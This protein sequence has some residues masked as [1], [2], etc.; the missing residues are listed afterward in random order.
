MATF[1]FGATAQCALPLDDFSLL[2]AE[3]DAHPTLGDP[4]AA[5]EAALAAPIGFPPL[6]AATAPGDVVAIAVAD[7][8]PQTN[9]IVTGAVKALLEAGVSPAMITIV[10]S[11]KF[12]NRAEL[13]QS[14]AKL[15]AEE[16]K[17]ELHD[18]DDE[19]TIAMVGVNSAKEPLRLNRTL[20]EADLVLP[21]TVQRLPEGA[22]PDESKFAG[23]FPQ[24]SSRET[25]ARVRLESGN[26]SPKV[27]KRLRA[28][29]DE[30]GW[31]LG[32]QMI[33]TVAP[34][35]NGGVAGVL[36]GDPDAVA[37]A[38]AA[39]TRE[40]WEQSVATPGDLVIAG[41]SGSEREQTWENVARAVAAASLVVTPGGAI[42]VCSELET[43]P[44]GPLLRL[45]EAVDFNEVQ[46]ELTRDEANDAHPAVVLA[47]AL[48]EGPVYLRSR[49]PSDVVESLGMTPIESDAELARLA[50]GR[51]HTIII[52]EAQRL[53]PRPIIRDEW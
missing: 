29:A 15:N 16:M 37:K 34:G 41:V 53:T 1:R 13:E 51:E 48:E 7:G 24:F 27:Q 5:V 47:K 6:V 49:L 17:F 20:A 36:A 26:E 46:R 38:G 32:V 10:S 42:A 23:L 21:I 11:Q 50:A 31:L 9:A 25:M 43:S 30:A 4:A 19:Q 22:Q 18:P 12:E 33:V 14:L 44:T 45:R 40:I 52:E 39:L 35:A 28:E 3:S 2:S 8:V